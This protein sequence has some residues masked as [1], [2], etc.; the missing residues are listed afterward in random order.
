MTA[1]EQY[2]TAIDA[3]ARAQDEILTA[4]DALRAAGRDVS[5]LR[6]LDDKLRKARRRVWDEWGGL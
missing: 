5:D 2:L 3:L 1:D 4:M 6:P